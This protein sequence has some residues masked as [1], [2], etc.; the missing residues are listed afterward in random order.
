[1]LMSAA[2]VALLGAVP[3]GSQIWIGQVVGNLMQPIP[4]G[5]WCYDG[6]RLPKP[7]KVQL[8][9]PYAD[10]AI[11][12]YERLASSSTGIAP[13]FAKDGHWTLDGTETDFHAA[14][15][16][17]VG[18]GTHLVPESYVRSTY[19]G[20]L[21]VRWKAVAPTAKCLE[22]M[23]ASCSPR[24]AASRYESCTSHRHRTQFNPSR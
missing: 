9:I 11:A 8:V 12:E 24:R 22:P 18:A 17:W 19:G 10:K 21:L 7:R 3:A 16:P 23:T 14:H 1:M 13:I 15:D 20:T 5:D 2:A 6:S 4:A